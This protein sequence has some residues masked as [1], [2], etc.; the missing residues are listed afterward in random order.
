[1]S[2]TIAKHD[3]RYIENEPSR[4]KGLEIGWVRGV[5]LEGPGVRFIKGKSA[6]V[7]KYR[8]V[9]KPRDQYL[10]VAGWLRS[11]PAETPV[12]FRNHLKISRVLDLT[13]F[14]KAS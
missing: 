10:R 5:G 8:Q 13:S 6:G 7:P 14:G 9:S 1:M 2:K 12:K 4:D 11:T 3:I